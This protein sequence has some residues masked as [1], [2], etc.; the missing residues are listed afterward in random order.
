MKTNSITIREA[1]IGDVPFLVET[2]IEAEK[3]STDI[4]SYSTVFGLSQE[5]TGSYL[6]EML[7]EEVDGCEL[8]ISSFLVAEKEG[9][10]VGA[11]SAWIEGDC[12][13]PSMILKG[14]LLSYT[15]PKTCLERSV[16]LHPLLQELHI[17]YI[18]GAIQKGAGYVVESCRGHQILGLLTEEIIH[19]LRQNRP[20]VKTVYTQIYGSNFR[21]IN[22]NRKAGFEILLTKSSDNEAILNYLPSQSKVMMK[23]DL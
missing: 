19:H 5:Q 4:L 1:T 3:S 13:L 21:A 15:L 23:K 14:N 9:K 20:E 8:S 6:S 10:L 22:A 17:D 7:S 11:V 18:P 12:G 2:I 16:T